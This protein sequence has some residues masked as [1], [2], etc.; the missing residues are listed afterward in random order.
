MKK[1]EESLREDT[2]KTGCLI[3]VKAI[4]KAEQ[5]ELIK[6]I[7][8]EIN[9][10]AKKLNTIN[11]SNAIENHLASKIEGLEQTKIIIEGK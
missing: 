5:D 6:K 4:L 3:T 7:D 11:Q 2:N 1:L 10:L 9:K 8:E